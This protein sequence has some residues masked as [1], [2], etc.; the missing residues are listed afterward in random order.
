M[1]DDPVTTEPTR[2]ATGAYTFM[3]TVLIDGLMVVLEVLGNVQ[4]ICIQR[5]GI[6]TVRRE[7]CINALQGRIAGIVLTGICADTAVL[8][9]GTLDVRP[10]H[11]E[12]RCD[13]GN[14]DDAVLTHL[15]VIGAIRCTIMAGIY[16][17]AVMTTIMVMNDAHAILYGR[18]RT[19]TLHSLVINAGS[20]TF[21]G[22][23]CC[24]NG[25][26]HLNRSGHIVGVR[27]CNNPM[28][29]IGNTT[30]RLGTTPTK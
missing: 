23:A 30:L 29:A 22:M 11:D 8:L 28:S 13:A 21:L 12:V 19:Q 6:E 16:F 24:D 25:V 20:I 18:L 17:S 10:G 27:C 5:T 1:P 3:Y 2:T 14:A 4:K 9:D 26:L 15:R 7:V